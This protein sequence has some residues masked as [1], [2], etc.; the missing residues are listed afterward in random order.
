ML[1]GVN[2]KLEF[3]VG[4]KIFIFVFAFCFFCVSSVFADDT[5]DL[6]DIH[7]NITITANSAVH[8]YSQ[9]E[10]MFG[11]SGGVTEP[12]HT[13]FR[14]GYGDGFKHWV[15]WNTP[16]T[17]RLDSFSLFLGDDEPNPYRGIKEFYLYVNNSNSWSEFF[18]QTS[19][20]HP[21]NVSIYSLNHTFSPG[22][23]GQFFRAEF[24]QYDGVAYA[25]GCRVIELN[26]YGQ[27][28]PEPVSA[29]LFLLGAGAL[30]LNL[31]RKKK[32]IK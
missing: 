6:W 19:F 16:N 9:I 31:Y 4:L 7:Q 5:T 18:S 8:S 13:L 32:I 21:Y 28:V 29:T 22:I 15:E 20:P 30:G 26:G 2:S 27:V 23:V 25:Q 10:N 24:V 11:G 17:I 1:G 14:D 12:N 3:L